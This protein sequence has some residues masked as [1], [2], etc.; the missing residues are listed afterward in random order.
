[1]LHSLSLQTFFS[2]YRRGPLDEVFDAHGD[3]RPLYRSFI[4]ALVKTGSAGLAARERVVAQTFQGLGITFALPSVSGN[5]ERPIPFDILP[6]LISTDHWQRIASGVAQRVRALNAF[7][8]DVYGDQ[9]ILRAGIIPE[10]FIYQSPLFTP[11]MMGVRVPNDVWITVAGIDVVRIGEESYAVLEDN[12]RSPSGVSYVLENRLISSRLWAQLMRQHRV[13]PVSQYPQELLETLFSIREGKWVVLTPGVYNSAYFEHSLLANQMGLDL[14]EAQDLVV[15]NHQLHTRTTK[16]LQPVV[17]AYRRV[18]EEYL[19]P[20]TFRPDSVIGVPGLGQLLPQ[21]QLA[22]ANAVGT[23]IG[24]DKAVYRYVPQMIAYYLGES[25]LL[26]NIPTYLPSIPK[27]QDY[28][29]AHWKDLVIKP[30][31]ASGGK[32]VQFGD[33]LDK[34]STQSLQQAIRQDPRQFIAQPILKFSQ[35]PCYAD[36][37]WEPRYIDLRPFCLNGAQETVVLPGGLTRVSADSKNR[38]VNS[39][40]GGSTKDT[41][42]ERRPLC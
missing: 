33:K 22:L 38:I 31:A 6:R 16:G 27:E 40:Q 23:G 25:P 1:M 30:V 9:R 3:V 10:E 5:I 13:S 36:G 26:E 32:G 35:A 15:H 14:V 4:E 29:F 34:S 12:V 8:A 39:S 41:W 21:Q 28:I 2:D 18:D 24:D 11:Q 7:I 37:E 42:V 19:D 20:L 17:G